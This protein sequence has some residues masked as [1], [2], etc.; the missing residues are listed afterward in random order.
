MPSFPCSLKRV[1]RLPNSMGC[2][3]VLISTRCCFRVPAFLPGT[4]TETIER[5][6]YGILLIAKVNYS[7]FRA[8]NQAILRNRRICYTPQPLVVVCASH[9]ATS[10]Y[11]ASPMLYAVCDRI[12]SS[13]LYATIQNVITH[14][15]C[16]RL[17]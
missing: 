14:R 15:V 4:R 6:S 17:V 1:Q 2:S 11:V 7:P 16:I 9:Y 5:S 3:S 8:K 12:T 13:T 10:G